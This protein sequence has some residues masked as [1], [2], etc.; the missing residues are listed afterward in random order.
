MP[1]KVSKG[2]VAKETTTSEEE[3]D[4]GRDSPELLKRKRSSTPKD[5]N[6]Q[7]SQTSDVE[8]Q[9]KVK[10]SSSKDTT[11]QTDLIYSTFTQEQITNL[12]NKIIPKLQKPQL[13]T[14]ILFCKKQ[15]DVF[16]HLPKSYSNKDPM[17][18]YIT[19]NIENIKKQ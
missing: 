16:Q 17:V 11:L 14:I 9:N 4:Y 6:S 7:G 18:T 5:C 13:Q 10:A 8:K 19:A 1:P 2:V 15:P 3:C 12:E